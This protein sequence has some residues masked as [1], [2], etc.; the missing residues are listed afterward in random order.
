LAGRDVAGEDEEKTSSELE[1]AR[2]ATVS[3]VETRKGT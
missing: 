3:P 1:M 2:L